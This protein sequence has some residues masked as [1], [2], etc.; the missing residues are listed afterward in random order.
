MI[1]NY[2]IGR[3]PAVVNTR[4]AILVNDIGNALPDSDRNRVGSSAD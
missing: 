4:Q 1:I 2:M 3:L